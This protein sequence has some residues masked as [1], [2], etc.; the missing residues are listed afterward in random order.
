MTFWLPMRRILISHITCL[1][2][3]VAWP[4]VCAAPLTP[5]VQTRA[6]A[7]AK[8]HRLA[9]QLIVRL[10]RNS[11][12]KLDAGEW[13]ALQSAGALPDADADGLAD[14]AEIATWLARYGR[15]RRPWLGAVGAGTRQ[16]AAHE[17]APPAR[18]APTVLAEPTADGQTP[19]AG[20]TSARPRQTRFFVPDE[21]LPA[22]LPEWFTARDADGDGQLTLSEYSPRAVPAEVREFSAW[23]ADGDGVVTVREYLSRAGGK[24][25]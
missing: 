6:A 13:M 24:T 2:Y 11:D 22:G 17:P 5:T 1:I 25:P 21:A 4:L 14:A 16:S 7:T 10:D 20:R 9:A 19:P 15:G 18:A 23:D 8:L 12:H 3:F